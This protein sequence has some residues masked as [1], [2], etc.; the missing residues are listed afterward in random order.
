MPR[1][2]FT[3]GT[4]PLAAL[5]CEKARPREWPALGP[6]RTPRPQPESTP[7]ECGH[8]ALSDAWPGGLR[9]V[10]A[11]AAPGC[12]SADGPS[13]PRESTAPKPGVWG[14][15][16]LGRPCGLWGG[17]LPS[18]HLLRRRPA[19]SPLDGRL[20]QDGPPALGVPA[21]GDLHEHLQ[22]E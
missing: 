22:P 9:P 15:L 17:R 4:V 6:E 7:G 1:G 19:A 13:R 3:L 8:A 18:P 5:Y 20:P 16:V 2:V 12:R 10:P 14:D 11:P 21:R